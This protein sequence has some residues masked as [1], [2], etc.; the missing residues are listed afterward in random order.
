MQSDAPVGCMEGELV[1]LI[2]S[3]PTRVRLGGGCLSGGCWDEGC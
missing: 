2:F 1:N 3:I